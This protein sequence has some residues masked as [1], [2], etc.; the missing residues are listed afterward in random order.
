MI[1]RIIVRLFIDVVLLS[2]FAFHPAPPF[3]PGAEILL[4][5]FIRADSRIDALRFIE[6]TLQRAR[7]ARELD[8]ACRRSRSVEAAAERA[9][10]AR[11]AN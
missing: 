4:F 8:S 6:R 1:V 3:H 5:V 10:C 2:G 7:T 9:R 11:S